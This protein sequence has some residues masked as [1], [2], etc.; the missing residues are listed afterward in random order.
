MEVVLSKSTLGPIHLL[1]VDVRKEI[2]QIALHTEYSTN[3]GLIFPFEEDV[4]DRVAIPA[5]LQIVWEN[6]PTLLFTSMET[7]LNLSNSNLF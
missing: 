5:T 6:S 4:E 1:K 7:F 3:M 2:Y